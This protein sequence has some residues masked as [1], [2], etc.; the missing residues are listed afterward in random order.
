MLE[1][2]I[3]KPEFLY[4]TTIGR[5][6]GEPHEIE[7]WYVPQGECYYL[8]SGGRTEADWVKNLLH[9]PHISFRVQGQTYEGTGRAIDRATETELADSVDELMQAKYQWNDGLIIELSPE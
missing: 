9:N 8:I 6:S 3:Y 2:R 4:L 1:P 7:I 5:K